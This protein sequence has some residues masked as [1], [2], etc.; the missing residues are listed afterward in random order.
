MSLADTYSSLHGL[1][2]L[3]A[4]LRTAEQ[5]G[6]G[7]HIDIAM[8]NVIHSIDD[9]AHWA[10]DNVWPKPEENIVWDAPEDK[11]I[12]I[13]AD[14]KWIWITFSTRDGMKDPTPE[15]ADLETKIRLRREKLT[16]RI[17]S[18]DTF[19]AL[20]VKLD[21]LNLA[22]GKVRSFGDDS[23]AQPSVAGRDVL[24]ERIAKRDFARRAHRQAWRG[25][26]ISP[27]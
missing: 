13:C 6:Q 5:T 2:G 7:Q 14:M 9:Y 15:G 26:C 10:L 3:L 21:E 4:A 8:I 18:F 19:D 1:V 16:E 24:V 23:L 22:W 25:Q 11:K 20:T 12:L 27:H 17:K